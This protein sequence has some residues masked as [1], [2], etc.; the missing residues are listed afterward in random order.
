MDVDGDFR[1]ATLTSQNEP[2]VD[3][4]TYTISHFILRHTVV[5]SGPLVDLRGLA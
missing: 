5:L 3:C 2:S 4:K 1:R